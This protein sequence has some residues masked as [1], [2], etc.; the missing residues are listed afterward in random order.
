MDKDKLLPC[1]FCGGKARFINFYSLYMVECETCRAATDTDHK[2]ENAI[3]IW[4]TRT[5]K[6]TVGNGENYEVTHGHINKT[7]DN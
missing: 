2:K 6:I 5:N 7:A 4:N 1:P 3:K